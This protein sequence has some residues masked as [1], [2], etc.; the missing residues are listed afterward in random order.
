MLK[1]LFLGDEIRAICQGLTG[2]SGTYHT[3]LSMKYGTNFVGG[4]TPGKGGSIHLNLPI[5][6]TVLDAIKETNANTSVIFVPAYSCKDAI[7]EAIYSGIKLIICVTEGM[8]TI[9]MLYIKNILN[10][11]KSILIG[12]NSPGLVV[13]NSCRLGIMP[14]NIHKLGKVGIISRSG[15]L[16][17]E[18]IY[19]TTVLGIGQSI[20]IG[21]GGDQIVGSDFISILKFLNNDLSTEIILMIGE[22]G[23]TL[24]ERASDFIKENIKKPVFSY[25]AGVTSPPGKRMGHAGA[26]ISSNNRNIDKKID[27]LSSKGIHIITSV[28]DIGTTINKFI[29]NS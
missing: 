6:N 4:V 14:T 15:T 24:E 3:S 8:P 12:P 2:K 1:N 13:P 29:I 20:S 9:D 28:Y 23:G 10:N 25:I 17:Y 16:T 7:L 21:I 26:I 27:Y 11:E 19:Q 22:I 5:F 18:A